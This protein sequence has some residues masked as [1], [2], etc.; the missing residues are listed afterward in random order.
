MK[1]IILWCLL[2][3]CL[4][5]ASGCGGA[6]SAPGKGAE[7]KAFKNV[8]PDQFDK[9]RA[10]KNAVV[11]DVRTPKEFA[12]GHIPGATNLDW[13]ASDF[14]EKVTKLDKSKT[15]L[16]HCATG[17][18]SAL[19]CDKLGSRLGFTNCF[20]LEGGIKAWQQ[21]DKPVVK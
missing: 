8:G 20:N 2:A 6:D 18:R 5:L 12:G 17:R 3:G 1:P 14:E 19:A 9:L 7:T 13:N 11:L 10:E 4:C 21:A 16:V 15:Y